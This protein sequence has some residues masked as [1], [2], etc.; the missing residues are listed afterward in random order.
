M[1][2]VRMLLVILLIGGV[3]T[4]FILYNKPTKLSGI[5]S[6]DKSKLIKE[7]GG[8]LDSSLAIFPDDVT[9][10]INPEYKSSFQTHLFDSIGYIILSTNYSEE[11]FEE[12]IKRMEGLSATITKTCK[13]NSETFTNT[14]RYNDGMYDLPVYLTIDGFGS[15]YEYALIDRDNLKITYVYLS[16]PNTNNKEYYDYLKKEKSWY[17]NTDTTHLYSMYNH[18]FDDGAS[19]AEYDDCNKDQ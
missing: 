4:L 7:Y 8:D 18:S 16:Y 2:I 3:S 1:K 11:D 6:Y 15:T 12:E 17:S 14:V 9:K 5:D 19:Y 10:L 13:P